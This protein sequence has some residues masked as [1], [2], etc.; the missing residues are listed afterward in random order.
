MSELVAYKRLFTLINVIL[1]L[2]SIFLYHF[3]FF[4]QISFWVFLVMCLVVC[5]FALY[6]PVMVFAIFVG[7]IP[8]EIINIAPDVIGIS[9]RPYQ[10]L[11]IAAIFGIVS[12]LLFRK[13]IGTLFRWNIFDVVVVTLFFASVVSALINASS[14]G[15]IK[16][17]VVFS[18]FC[19]IYFVTR[20]FV[21]TK[22]EV[23]A[24]FPL[25]ISSGVVVS[26]YAITQNILF[27]VNLFHLEVMPGRPNATFVEPDW[28]GVYL[29]FVF[30][31]CLSYLYYN[32]YH[33]HLWR[34]FDI[35][36]YGATF[37][38]MVAMTITVARSAWMGTGAVAFVYFVF[39][40]TQK[41]YKLFARHFL[42]TSSLIFMSIVSVVIFQFTDFELD[43]RVESTKTGRQEITVACSTP[44][45]RDAL[46]RIGY[47]AHID[48]LVQYDCAH[49]DLEDI[50]REMS[51]GNYVFKID[52]DDPN[53]AVRSDVYKKTIVAFAQQP[54][55]GY[56]WGSSARIYGVDAAGTPLNASN[57]FFETAI[58][59]GVGG[60][61]IICAFL[62]GVVCFAVVIMRTKSSM[63]DNS[64]ALF[65]VLGIV[66]I[67]VPNLFNAGLFLGFVWVYFGMVALMPK[68]LHNGQK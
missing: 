65:G 39:L 11:V 50:D 45:S 67:V 8:L 56:G 61:I 21:R 34:F 43:N 63:L 66:G 57:I 22:K 41:K 52:R 58:A 9:L 38:I 36:L 10:L 5:G 35:A 2:I 1:L 23:I 37:L 6:R 42:W 24:L 44:A 17:T 53:I 27:S 64:I 3:G 40:I 49:I 15:V 68:I 55:F 12:I 28:L 48:E 46:M 33:K 25:F 30:T 4:S 29:V 54:I 32:A 13:K 31:V 26:L 47:V 16:Q 62:L 60:L 14:G 7:L 19:V 51:L 59:T 20:F 18:S